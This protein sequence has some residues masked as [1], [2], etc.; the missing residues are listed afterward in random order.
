[1]AN[2]D[3]TLQDHSHLAR[4]GMATAYGDH[5][6]FGGPAAVAEQRT[7]QRVHPQLDCPIQVDIN[8]PDFID[9]LVAT[10]ISANGMGLQ[11]DHEF[12][13]CNLDELV[14]IIIQLPYPV[15]ESISVMGRIIHLSDHNFGVHFVGVE[16]AAS[17]KIQRYVS[18]RSGD[19]P[20]W[21]KYLIPWFGH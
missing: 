10:D 5:R 21:R 8:G 18:F 16:S 11:V 6:R 14:S 9:V 1:M 17:E 4:M 7:S 12:A 20:F 19:M 2:H 15:N 3:E 13:G